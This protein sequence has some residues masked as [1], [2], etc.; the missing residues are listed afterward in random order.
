MGAKVVFLRHGDGGAAVAAPRRVMVPA[1]ALVRGQNAVS[2]WIVENGR[3]VSRPV[4]TG[5]EHDGKIEVRSGLSG[6]ESVVL[7]PPAG[8]RDGAR[9]RV[10]NS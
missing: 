9:V 8:L 2:V 6:G 3:A 4:D 1:A 7:R 10:S 5:L